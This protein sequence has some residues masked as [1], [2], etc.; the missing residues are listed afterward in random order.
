MFTAV[1]GLVLSFI[2]ESALGQKVKAEIELM[3]MGY[4]IENDSF[5]MDE[6]SMNELLKS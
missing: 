4:E 6:E 1:S 5:L 2:A 3:K